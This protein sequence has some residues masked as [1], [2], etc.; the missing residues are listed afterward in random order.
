MKRGVFLA[1]VVTAFIVLAVLVILFLNGQNSLYI[2]ILNKNVSDMSEKKANNSGS[3]GPKT[4]TIVITK[5]NSLG[6]ILVGTDGRTL[7]MFRA[8]LNGQSKCYGSCAIAWPP[9]TI[10]NGIIPTGIGVNTTL[11][12]V[13]RTDG[14]LQVTANGMPL[15]Y[16]IEDTEPGE[17][18][19]QAIS[20]YG[21]E[22]YVISSSGQIITTPAEN[23]SNPS[24]RNGY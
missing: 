16:Y 24:A 23:S 7:Y 15:Y 12:V 13:N 5:N 18:N 4:E 9:L 21:A 6:D 3:A 19:G 8:D 1:I 20:T 14:T 11:G 2:K 17:I 10:V 22:W